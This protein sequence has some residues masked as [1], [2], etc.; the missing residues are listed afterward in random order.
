MKKNVGS[1]FSFRH[2]VLSLFRHSVPDT[3]SK[4]GKQNR[5]RRI[6]RNN[7]QNESGRSMLE[8]LAVM[9]IMTLVAFGSVPMY[10]YLTNREMAASITED[11]MVRAMLKQ[12]ERAH[13][14]KQYAIAMDT[15]TRQGDYL[16]QESIFNNGFNLQYR[17]E[18]LPEELCTA[19]LKE[20]WQ[21][22]KLVPEYVSMNNKK[23]IPTE[24]GVLSNPPECN[25]ENNL[26]EVVFA[27]SYQNPDGCH[28]DADCPANKYCDNLMCYPKMCEEN[29]C[30]VAGWIC[31]AHNRCTIPCEEGTQCNCPTNTI[32]DGNGSCKCDIN[33]LTNCTD[34]SESCV[35]TACDE[36][37]SVKEGACESCIP[38]STCISCTFKADG[39]K[40]YAFKPNGTPCEQA[41]V[42]GTCNSTGR[43]V[44]KNAKSCSSRGSCPSGQFCNYGGTYTPNVCEK[45]S[46][47]TVKI[48]GKTYFINTEKDLHSWCRGD[49]GINCAWG[50]L[51]G[52]SALDWCSS[53]GIPIIKR[54]DFKRVIG[55]LKP[56]LPGKNHSAAYWYDYGSSSSVSHHHLHSADTDEWGDGGRMDG[57]S[58]A[59]GVICTCPDGYEVNMSTMTCEPCPE[60]ETCGCHNCCEPI[61][62]CT[63]QDASCACTECAEGYEFWENQCMPKCDE[64]YFRDSYGDCNAC[65]ES[66]PI[67]SNE[68]E[69]RKC[70][71]YGY[72]RDIT[73]YGYCAYQCDYGY[74]R[75]DYGYCY[76]CYDS[77]SV[78]TTED[79]CRKCEDYGVYR[80]MVDGYCEYPCDGG[81][82]DYY[83]YCYYCYDDYGVY[84]YQEEC[85]KCAEYGEPREMEGD[86]CYRICYE[87]YFRDEYGYCQYC[88]D[89]YAYYATEEQCDRCGDKREMENSKCVYKCNEN[90]FRDSNGDCRPCNSTTNYTASAEECGKC[91]TPGQI[92]EIV[93]GTCTLKCAEGEFKQSSGACVSCS[94]DQ[95]PS[96]TET[97]CQK[98]STTTPRKMM[99]GKCA[100]ETCADGYFQA[101][102][103]SSIGRCFSCTSNTSFLSDETQCNRCGD[104]REMQG[105]YCS[106]NTCLSGYFRVSD[107]SCIDCPNGNT[108]TMQNPE[109]C[110]ACNDSYYPRVINSSG[111]CAPKTTCEQGEFNGSSYSSACVKCSIPTARSGISAE[112]CAACNYTGSPYPRERI[113][114]GSWPIYTYYCR[115]KTCD[116][117]YKRSGHDCVVCAEG[118]TCNCADGYESDG[119]GGCKEKNIECPA[120]EYRENT[121]KECTPCPENAT[122]TDGISFTCPD[123]Q[124]PNSTG[125]ECECVNGTNAEGNCA[126]CS[127]NSQCSEID[128]NFTCSASGYCG[129][130]TED[131]NGRSQAESECRNF[132]G[133]PYNCTT[134][135]RNGKTLYV[136]RCLIK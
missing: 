6:G 125:T 47:D 102:S 23:R 70:E 69:C 60:G 40:Q 58:F 75:D 129:G 78:Y 57:Y 77:Y 100:R 97:E 71:D 32:A 4:K 72:P 10:T 63:T 76:D 122:C 130:E 133:T 38:Y 123:R 121:T 14:K 93:N 54:A 80:S 45:V 12:E 65:W 1:H 109:D 26:L 126:I 43:C 117:A 119:K 37:Y 8:M 134:E 127:S 116:A 35:C 34:H 73:D 64:G 115:R 84:T 30:P 114:T 39:K 82:K 11:I 3:E 33:A 21:K 56:Y 15:H 94:T 111:R 27:T 51:S 52:Y 28:E 48:N 107:G 67:E 61:D 103:G 44:P 62:N 22:V 83:G 85:D 74:F 104:K 19:L 46:Y 120:G 5:F 7:G 131:W 89:D 29:E 36:F 132:G 95:A 108:W 24:K 66:Y 118:E 16:I 90:Y 49:G 96:A 135:D 128:I 98:C 13:K 9:A 92:R 50:F 18:G 79:E 112:A 113:Q 87:D 110:D 2:T 68:D 105:N 17:I 101:T 41:G 124:T 20:K 53:L 99:S 59:G 88:E 55:E 42:S 25:E 31:D 86:Y 106:L 91:T 136:C 81:F